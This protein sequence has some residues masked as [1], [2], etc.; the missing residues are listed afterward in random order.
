MAL[1]WNYKLDDFMFENFNIDS[2][3]SKNRRNKPNRFCLFL[4]NYIKECVLV[5]FIVF[6]L[7]YMTEVFKTLQ[8]IID[9]H[10]ATKWISSSVP[11]I[12]EASTDDERAP[13]VQSLRIP[14]SHSYLRKQK[15]VFPYNYY[16]KYNR[17][18]N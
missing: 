9:V 2:V 18:W 17:T 15:L 8:V 12:N 14:S 4:Y 6:C 5:V 11:G 16:I 7:A 1:N 3:K 13:L 10:F